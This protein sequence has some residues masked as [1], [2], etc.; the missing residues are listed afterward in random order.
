MRVWQL[1]DRPAAYRTMDSGPALAL[2]LP[3]RL[4]QALLQ[5]KAASRVL[6]IVVSP[7]SSFLVR[8]RTR[9]G[10]LLFLSRLTS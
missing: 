9:R 1:V 2:L 5:V 6:K 3:S 4:S 8:R 7:G 10:G